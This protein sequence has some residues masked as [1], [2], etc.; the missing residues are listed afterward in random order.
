MESSVTASEDQ[1]EENP[2]VNSVTIMLPTVA[3]PCYAEMPHSK[4]AHAL[5][6]LPAGVQ[7]VL[8]VDRVLLGILDIVMCSA[9]CLLDQDDLRPVNERFG[10]FDEAAIELGLGSGPE[11]EVAMADWLNTFDLEG[12][13]EQLKK[14]KS[15]SWR[16]FLRRLIGAAAYDR[17]AVAVRAD[18]QMVTD[19]AEWASVRMQPFA[20]AFDDCMSV[21]GSDRVGELIG[22]QDGATALEVVLRLHAAATKLQIAFGAELDELVVAPITEV[23]QLADELRVMA[24]GATRNALGQL[25]GDLSRKLEGARFVLDES[26]DGVSQAANSLVEL[27]DRMLRTAFPPREVLNWLAETGRAGSDYVHYPS[28]DSPRPTKRAEA[29]CFVYGGNVI[30]RDPMP[31]LETFADVVV[32]IRSQLQGIKHAD[33]GSREEAEQ[34]RTLIHSIEGFITIVIRLGWG[35][36]EADRVAEIR[37]RFAA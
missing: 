21:L 15:S 33:T 2:P 32:K 35:A 31:V 37:S 11:G 3:V 29:L 4:T 8:G 34:V 17:I 30:D 5:E 27:L 13:L 26:V 22:V 18:A 20:V 1:G 7:R 14:A 23:A 12:R 16:K 36:M 24:S 19:V 25:S 9:H 10:W 6:A 28:A